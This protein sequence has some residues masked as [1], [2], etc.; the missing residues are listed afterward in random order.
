[1]LIAVGAGLAVA[2][3]ID[4]ILEARQ[5]ATK[6]PRDEIY[7]LKRRIQELELKVRSLTEHNKF[8][9]TQMENMRPRR[10]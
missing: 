6:V 9:T 1:M 8:L 10:Q 5:Q 7:R 3:R 4:R 2:D